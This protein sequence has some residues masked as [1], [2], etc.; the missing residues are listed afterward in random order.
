TVYIINHTEKSGI[1]VYIGETTDIY[2]RTIEHIDTDPKDREDWA[3]M[4]ASSNAKMLVVGHELFNKSLTLDI[5]NRLMLYLSS[6]DGVNTIY[7]RRSNEQNEYYTSEYL[8]AIFS[9][10]WKKLRTKHKQL[11]PIEKVIKDSALFKASPFHKLTREQLDAKTTIYHKIVSALTRNLDSQLIFVD[12][13]AG[14][15]KTVLLSSL[16]YDLF[17]YNEEKDPVFQSRN[18]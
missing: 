8:D 11:F 17:Q 1:S 10:V 4:K 12:G 2:R 6:V 18:N 9:K 14:T 13:E 16:F 7:N 3:I 5:E 15:G